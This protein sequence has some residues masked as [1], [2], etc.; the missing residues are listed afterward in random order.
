VEGE[1]DFA[2]CVVGVADRAKAPDPS[3]VQPGDAVI[4]LASTGLHT[5]G[6]SLARKALLDV[7]G[8]HLESW[9]PELGASLGDALLAVH[10]SY[11]RAVTAAYEGGMSVRVMAHITGGGLYDNIPRVLPPDARVTIDRRSWTPPPIFDLIQKCGDI[12]DVEMHRTF[13]MGVGM[14][15]IV[16]RGQAPAACDF[17]NEQGEVAWQIGEVA[18]GPREVLII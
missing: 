4:G 5:N 18:R 17:F 15:L 10:R 6:Y 9:V 3:L 11:L 8:Y 1:C 2:G 12:P 13:N 7:G 16:S 14:V